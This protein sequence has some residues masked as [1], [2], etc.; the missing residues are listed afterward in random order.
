MK[1]IKVLIPAGGSG[2]RFNNSEFVNL[3][4]FIYIHGKTMFE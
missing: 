1:K 3:K 2:T 4:P